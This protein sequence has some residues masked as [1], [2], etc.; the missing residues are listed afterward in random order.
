MVLVVQF[1]NKGVRRHRLRRV[2]CRPGRAIGRVGEDPRTVACQE[3]DH[4]ERLGIVPNHPVAI[5]PSVPVFIHR[6]CL[7]NLDELV[8]RPRRLRHEFA[9]V[10]QRQVVPEPV[11]DHQQVFPARIVARGQP[12][13][14]PL[15][16]F[17]AEL[18]REIPRHVLK[19]GDRVEYTHRVLR[20]VNDVRPTPGEHRRLHAATQLLGLFVEGT[21]HRFRVKG[22][23]LFEPLLEHLAGPR[24]ASGARA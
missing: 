15:V 11:A 1:G 2:Q 19:P 20:A 21:D 24:V 10:D 18:R 14:R 8:I 3:R 17:F 23:E 4:E 13:Q 12:H 9:V 7:G 22:A 6:V 5:R 16:E